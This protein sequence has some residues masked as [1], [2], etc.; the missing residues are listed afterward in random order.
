MNKLIILA[1]AVSITGCSSTA[2]IQDFKP[3]IVSAISMSTLSADV[4]TPVVQQCDGSG[5]I[6]Q[7]DGH[8]T[9][10]LGCPKCQPDGRVRTSSKPCGDKCVCEVCTCSDKKEC[11]TKSVMPPVKCGENCV[12]E[13]G[14]CEC[15]S[16]QECLFPTVKPNRAPYFNTYADGYRES[17]RTGQ[18]IMVVV[19]YDESQYG[20]MMALANKEGRIFC[21]QPRADA[22][23]KDGVHRFNAVKPKMS[24]AE[25]KKVETQV[26][27]SG[28]CASCSRGRRR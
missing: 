27:S 21:V 2:V 26:F 18:P 7:G 6:T 17:L 25:V 1:L 4:V 9:K 11:L 8:K 16:G 23:L 3:L 10:C 13:D 15:K 28:G 14:K 12:C 19:G 24:A 20:S 5:W 22:L